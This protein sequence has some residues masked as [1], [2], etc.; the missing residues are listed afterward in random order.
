M[1][2][3]GVV[4]LISWLAILFL[5]RWKYQAWFVALLLPFGFVI[6]GYGSYNL[7]FGRAK[8]KWLKSSFYQQ[9][10]VI[11]KM[12]RRKIIPNSSNDEIISIIRTHTEGADYSEMYFSLVEKMQ[13]IPKGQD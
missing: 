11:E 3:G 4:I 2:V 13:E 9:K 12:K 6:F 7:S 10:N 1:Y 5:R 8:E